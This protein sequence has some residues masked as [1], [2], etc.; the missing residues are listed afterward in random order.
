MYSVLVI[1]GVISL[2]FPI[3]IVKGI[4]RAY[5]THGSHSFC[6]SHGSSGSC[7]SCGST[8]LVITSI[9][10]RVTF[11]MINFVLLNELKTQ[12]NLAHLFYRDCAPQNSNNFSGCLRKIKFKLV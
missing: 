7:G 4:L 3:S 8:V 5:V 9:T 2:S 10:F 6:G 11:K 1:F 12:Q